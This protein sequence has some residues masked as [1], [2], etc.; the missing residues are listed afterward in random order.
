MHYGS[1]VVKRH[2]PKLDK[3]LKRVRAHLK[4]RGS[5]QRLADHLGVI[6]PTLSDWLRGRNEPG[7]EVTLKLQEWVKRR[8]PKTKKK[9]ASVLVTPPRRLT[10]N[11]KS[12]S[13]EKAKSDRP[14][15]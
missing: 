3:L 15:G 13:N 10:R 4:Q 11:S 1:P 2:T 7:G 5:L 9:T 12:T 14:N 8:T 6:R